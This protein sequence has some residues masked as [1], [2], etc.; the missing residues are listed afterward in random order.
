MCD[1]C[2]F[3]LEISNSVLT[4]DFAQD[5]T[6]DLTFI[7]PP[8][9]TGMAICVLTALISVDFIAVFTICA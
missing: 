2:G 1:T 5:F 8:T 3:F 9:I 6:S 4:S 7:E